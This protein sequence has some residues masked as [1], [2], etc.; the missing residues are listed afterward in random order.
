MRYWKNRYQWDDETAA[1]VD[2]EAHGTCMRKFYSRRTFIVMFLSGWLPLGKLVSRYDLSYPTS[3]PGCGF[4]PE[5]TAH[6][7]QCRAVI[8]WQPELV[9]EMVGYNEDWNVPLW[10]ADLLRHV[11][12][13]VFNNVPV[14]V[15][16]IPVRYQLLVSR[17]A[18]VGW[19]Q[20]LYGRFVQEWA[21][22]DKQE[23]ADGRGRAWVA[24]LIM[25]IWKAVHNAWIVRNGARHGVT[26][27]A[28]E[29]ALVAQAQRETKAVYTLRQ[30]VQPIDQRLFYSS[31]EAHFQAEPTSKGLRQW[32]NT[33]GHHLR[34]SAAQGMQTGVAG[35][36]AIT[37]FFTP[38]P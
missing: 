17:Q 9:N 7:L 26:A 4:S 5:D 24:G 6:F 13:S 3:C 15:T 18:R 20:L 35:N 34:K 30:S 23:T 25:L 10:L 1:S 28:R 37:E 11:C 12:I 8:S 31:L 19:E 22:C 27:A 32:L 21:V 2:W 38:V 14:V 36:H 16:D 33:W 29:A